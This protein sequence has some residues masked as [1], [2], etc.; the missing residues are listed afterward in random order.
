MTAEPI[1]GAV[2]E[3]REIKG[4]S[5]WAD[6]WRR[7][8]GNRAAVVSAVLLII[9]ALLADLRTDGPAAWL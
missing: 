4:R 1:D 5:L 9:I 3:G 7:L 6:A 2:P 8:V